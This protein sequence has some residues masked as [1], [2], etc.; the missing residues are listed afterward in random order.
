MHTR[1]VSNE[2]GLR[3][4]F[5]GKQNEMFVN[6]LREALKIRSTFVRVRLSFLFS[7]P[8]RTMNERRMCTLVFRRR[9][10]LYTSGL[11]I[12]TTHDP[13]Y[14]FLYIYRTHKHHECCDDQNE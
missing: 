14:F 2:L 5:V 6:Y 9:Y 4:I 8:R 11:H 1:D 10:V 13:I 3:A 7:P 12:M